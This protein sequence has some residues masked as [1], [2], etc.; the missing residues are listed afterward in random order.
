MIAIAAL[1]AVFGWKF[2]KFVLKFGIL[3]FI[4]T[5]FAVYFFYN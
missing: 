5:L 1:V 4:S 2:F 3:A